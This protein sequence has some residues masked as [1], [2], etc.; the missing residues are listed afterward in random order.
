MVLRERIIHDVNSIA[1]LQLLNQLFDYMQVIK[2][3]VG[4]VT[5]NRDAVLR[6]ADTISDAEAA[7][8]RQSMAQEFGQIEG[9]W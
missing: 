3:N 7:E 8:L 1:D 2:R 6:F 9:E 4:Q 5:P